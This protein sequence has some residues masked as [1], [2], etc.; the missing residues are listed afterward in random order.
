MRHKFSLVDQASNPIRK[1]LVTYSHAFSTNRHTLLARSLLQHKGTLLVKSRFLHH[2]RSQQGEHFQVI[3]FENH[4]HY[5]FPSLMS[6]FPTPPIVTEYLQ[7]QGG[8]ACFLHSP[9]TCQHSS[10]P[11]AL[12]CQ[13]VFYKEVP[14]IPTNTLS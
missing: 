11:I 6:S 4:Q 5:P 3:G 9:S 7:P 2:E 13:T 1:W 14:L 10:L 12:D 8:K